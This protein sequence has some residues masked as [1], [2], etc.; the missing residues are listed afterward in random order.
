MIA[1]YSGREIIAASAPY[2]TRTLPIDMDK[3]FYDVELCANKMATMVPNSIVLQNLSN[4]HERVGIIQRETQSVSDAQ[5]IPV[6]RVV[7][8]IR[9]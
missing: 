3:L 1:Q 2:Y 7:F 9:S 4:S 5:T 8:S 6:Q